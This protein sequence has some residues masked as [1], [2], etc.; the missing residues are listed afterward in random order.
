MHSVLYV[1]LWSRGTCK[2]RAK[3]NIKIKIKKIKRKRN[4]ESLAR[5]AQ[6]KTN[7]KFVCVCVRWAVLANAGG[8]CEIML[9]LER[10][11]GEALQTLLRYCIE[12]VSWA[13]P[14]KDVRA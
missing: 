8:P 11:E 13:A 1:D 3:Q 4:R 14:W 9:M 12:L 2:L 10:I 5:V 7:F 6:E